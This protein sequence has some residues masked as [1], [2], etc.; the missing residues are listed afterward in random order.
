MAQLRPEMPV[1][2][3]QRI[4]EDALASVLNRDDNLA[5]EWDNGDRFLKVIDGIFSDQRMLF[6]LEQ[7]ARELEV[8]LS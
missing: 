5:V 6:S 3:R 4:I 2:E 7:I 1:F 8:L